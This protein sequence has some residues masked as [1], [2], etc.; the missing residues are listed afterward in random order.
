[1]LLSQDNIHNS[2]KT[3]CV[4]HFLRFGAPK[5]VSGP[6]L[7]PSWGHLGAVL[8][9]SWSRLGPSWHL[10]PS[11]GRLG[12][13]W[14]RLEPP[15]AD[16]GRFWRPS[17]KH[18]KSQFYNGKVPILGLFFGLKSMF[19]TQVNVTTVKRSSNTVKNKK[20]PKR[21]MYAIL[22]TS[23]GLPCCYVLCFALTN[24]FL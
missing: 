21:N 20:A 18:Q 10:G 11:W 2:T 3:S 7:G 6:L 9:P 4:L 22:C 17:E 8:G 23:V 24:P 19:L 15:K 1:M 12:P 16:F 5:P 14:G 13:S